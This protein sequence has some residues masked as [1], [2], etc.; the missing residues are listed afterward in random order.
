MHPTKQ[1]ILDV[2]G[3][4]PA[5]LDELGNSL[6]KFL[7]TN[8]FSSRFDRKIY[9]GLN[10]VG[11]RWQVSYN[12]NV[13]NTHNCPLSGVTNWQC[14]NDK[15]RGYPGFSGRIWVRYEKHLD[16]WGSEGIEKYLG[17]TGSGGATEGGP[18]SHIAKEYYTYYGARKRNKNNQPFNEPVIY[19]WDYRFY[20][21]DWPLIAKMVEQK[22]TF[23]LLKSTKFKMDHTFMWY[24]EN[25]AQRDLEMLEF[26]K[27]NPITQN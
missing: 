9:H 8:T 19:S 26:I 20:I 10:V 11:L 3:S 23:E 24:D 16:M 21:D 1:K 14:E 4:E 12:H 5:T 27:N 18:W 17:H 2:I 13:S 7:N 6:I 22:Q 25:T 15:P